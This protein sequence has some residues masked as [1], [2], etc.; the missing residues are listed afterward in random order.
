M[1]VFNN[2]NIFSQMNEYKN[3]AKLIICAFAFVGLTAC[4]GVAEVAVLPLTEGMT[5]LISQTE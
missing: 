5:L 4:G 3:I 2:R 1:A